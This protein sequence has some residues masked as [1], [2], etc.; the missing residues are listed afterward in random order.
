MYIL[1]IS[2]FQISPCW[3]LMFLGYGFVVVQA[4]VELNFK[5][6]HWER[7][8]KLII[9]CVFSSRWG[10][11]QRAWLVNDRGWL[12]MASHLWYLFSD[13]T[14]R[15]KICILTCMIMIKSQKMYLYI[16]SRPI[17]APTA[18]RWQFMLTIHESKWFIYGACCYRSFR[19]PLTS[20][21]LTILRSWILLTNGAAVPALII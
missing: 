7:R 1:R 9:F 13:Y 15:F 4:S 2:A 17:K 21:T 5:C 12:Q 14:V 10:P 11:G 3:T 20:Y 18:H 19:H 6:W 16:C 8:K